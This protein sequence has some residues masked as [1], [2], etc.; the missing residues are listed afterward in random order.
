MVVDASGGLWLA[1]GSFWSGL[2]LVALD[3][4]TMKPAYG[5]E[6]HSIATRPNTAIEAAYII[7]K[8]GYYYLFASIDHCCRGV[9]SDYKIIY[10][11]SRNITGT[12]Y[13][14]N[15]VSLMDGG[16]SLFDAGT[17]RWRGPG[18][19]SVHGTEAMAYHAYDA[20][21]NGAPTLLI[22]NLYWDAA[23]WPFKGN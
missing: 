11:R 18:G 2:K 15:G 14:K 16:G 21:N 10:G 9:N 12:Y 1:F 6:M 4:N 17:D 19:Q 13:D 3:S 7:Y 20:W 8:D 22:R 23:G 5:A